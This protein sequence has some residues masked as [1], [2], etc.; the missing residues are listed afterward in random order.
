MKEY[1]VCDEFINGQG[2]YYTIR[3]NTDCSP[4]RFVVI[5][6]FDTFKE[7]DEYVNMLR[8]PQDYLNIDEIEEFLGLKVV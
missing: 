5:A 6:D 8:H 1:V 2:G 3:A 7:A 4:A